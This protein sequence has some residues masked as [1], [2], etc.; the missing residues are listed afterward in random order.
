M[1][2][3]SQQQLADKADLSRDTIKALETAGVRTYPATVAAVVKVMEGEGVRFLNDDAFVGIM[4][5][6]N[7][8]QAG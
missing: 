2:S 5:D 8:D 7:S 6:V 1:L 4:L 3:W